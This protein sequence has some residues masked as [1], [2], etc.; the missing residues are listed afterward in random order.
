MIML[1]ATT[2]AFLILGLASAATTPATFSR[3]FTSETTRLRKDLLKDYDPRV[4]P[5]SNR[6]A[7]GVEYSGAGSD[8]AVQIRFFKVE[9]VRASHGDMRLKIWLRMYWYDE[10]LSWNAS[11][12]GGLA[13]ANF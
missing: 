7:S 10:R 2:R 11:D 13:Y 6:S 12:Y 4:P 1:I 9:S 3:D 8:I 5:L